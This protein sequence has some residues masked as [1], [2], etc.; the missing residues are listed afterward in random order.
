MLMAFPFTLKGKARQWMK[1]LS[2]GFITTWDLFKN[3]FLSKYHPSYQIIKQINAIRNFEQ[4][5]N[6]PLH[7]AWERFNNS[8]YNYI[9]PNNEFDRFT[10]EKGET[11]HQY[12]LRFAKLINDMNTIG[13]TMQ[14]LQV[15]TKFQN[16]LQPEWGIVLPKFLPTDDLI[17][18]LYKAM[19]FL[20]TAITSTFPQTNNQLRNSSNLRNQAAIQD[21][22]VTV[23]NIQG[24][25]TQSY[26]GNVARG[27]P[28]GTR[29]IQHTRN[30]TANQSKEAGVA[31]DKEQLAF[32]A[33]KWERVDS[34]T[35]THTLTTT[36]LRTDGIDGF[37]LECDKAPT[38]SAVFMA[39]L[40]AYGLDVLFKVPNYDTYHDNN[41]FEHSVQEMQYFEQHVIDDDSNIE[42]TN[43]NIVISYDQ[44]LK[45]NESKFVQSTASPEQHKDM[46]M[47]VIEKMSNQVAKYN[48]VY[49]ENKIVNESLTPELERYKEQKKKALENIVYKQGQSVQ[50]MHIHTLVKKHDALSVSDTK[51]TLILAEESR[52]K[53][54]EKQ[55]DPIEKEKKVDITPIDYAA[56]NI[57]SEHFVAHFVPQKQLSAE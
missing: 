9:I 21:S 15:K 22:E 8:L 48:A 32:L 5:S 29:V 20:N 37:D 53:M 4:E 25:Q 38:S 16:N 46:I 49:Q 41:V 34:G 45:E 35:Y 52:I 12:Y 6:K 10:S 42:I 57:L 40:S 44:Y 30:A 11:I 56:L 54:L 55:N 27:N 50:T 24:R 1:Q 39:N 28:T 36:I 19:S 31:L 17:K 7:L 23:Q 18:S 3:A 51:E 14:P 47:S 43:D 2:T 13:M 26:A 33:D